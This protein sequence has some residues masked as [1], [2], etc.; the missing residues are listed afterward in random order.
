[1]ISDLSQRIEVRR[2]SLSTD[3]G[4]GEPEQSETS[5]LTTWAAITEISRK[6]ALR[7][8]LDADTV[9]YQMRIRYASGRNIEKSDIIVW[10]S[11][12]Y[13]PRTTPKVIEIDKK[14]FLELIIVLQDG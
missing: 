5:V 4:F 13:Q 7:Q 2:V 8:A 9:Q 14:K 10:K 3:F 11:E 1:M 12:R 6:D